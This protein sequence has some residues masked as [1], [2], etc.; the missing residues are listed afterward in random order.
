M[1]W[2]DGKPYYSLN[3]YYRNLFGE[4]AYKISLDIGTTCPNRDGS[5]SSHGCVFCSEKGSGDYAIN[6]SDAITKQIDGAI[7][8][9]SDKYK[10]KAYIA[11]LQSFTNTYGDPDTLLTT[12]REILSDPRI[13]GLA[14]GTRPDCLNDPIMDGIEALSASYP[15]WIELGLQTIHEESA[16]YI[17]R[18]YPLEVFDKAVSSLALRQ[19]PVI[20]HLIAGLPTEND[21]DF[22]ASVRYLSSLPISGVKFHMLHVLKD[23]VLAGLYKLHPFPIMDQSHYCELICDAIC[24]LPPQIVIHR[25]TGDGPKDQL[26]APSWTLNKRSVLNDIHKTLKSRQLWQGKYLHENQ[27]AHKYPGGTHEQQ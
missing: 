2:P 24:L 7:D 18:C 10:G 15:I 8:M 25:M 9:I 4:K 23:T 16:A 22:L 1:K 5:L 6:A 19:L 26:I 17:N 13:Q 27:L 20:V 14:I 21:K 12:Y 3:Q 11:Y